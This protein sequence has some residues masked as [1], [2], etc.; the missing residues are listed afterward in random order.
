VVRV[1]NETSTLYIKL[2]FEH[3]LEF[4]ATS[5][6]EYVKLDFNYPAYFE[7]ITGSVLETEYAIKRIP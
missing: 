7:S 6:P 5:E 2:D 3:P 1:N 4:S